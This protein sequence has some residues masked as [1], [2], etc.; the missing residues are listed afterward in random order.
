LQK[1]KLHIDFKSLFLAALLLFAFGAKE[2]HHFFGHHHYEVKICAAAETG[3]VHL[4]NEEYAH[5]DCELC[6]FTFAHFTYKF[7]SFELK[8][9]LF[10]I[11]T[12][13]Y[14][15]YFLYPSFYQISPSQRGPPC[16]KRLII[17]T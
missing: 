17:N 10:W 3:D 13:D 15:Y 4:H 11:E 16:H 2:M 14:T 12:F 5:N 7:E 1:R 6:D 8:Q 9:P